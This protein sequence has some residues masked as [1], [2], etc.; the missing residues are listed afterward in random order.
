MAKKVKTE[1]VNE[2]EIKEA[3]TPEVEVVAKRE[4]PETA[5]WYVVSSSSNKENKTAELIKQRIKAN[6]LDEFVFEVVVPTQKKIVI[7]KGKKETVEERFLPGYIL[8]QMT[9]TE[10]VVHII[11]NTEGVVGF[12]GMTANS[13]TLTPL[14]KSFNVDSI[15]NLSKTTQA[16]VYSSRFDI[17]DAVKVVD[18]PFK[19]FVG[20]VQEVNE[21]KGQ[22]TV[23]LS[24]FGRETP[25]HLDFLQVN[26]I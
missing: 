9:P 26:K 18:G 25:V 11:R 7:K 1:K 23:L 2:V 10:D 21:A 19:D 24:V 12:L 5:K 4:I 20:N 6:N 22:V 16:P 8:I 3:N 13:K 15:L 14:D 17:N